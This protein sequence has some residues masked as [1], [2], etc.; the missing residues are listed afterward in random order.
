[1]RASQLGFLKIHL[2]KEK[3]V[4]YEEDLKYRYLTPYLDEVE[5]EQAE[6]KEFDYTDYKDND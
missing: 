1:M 5:T 4:T 3:W 2:P 6:I